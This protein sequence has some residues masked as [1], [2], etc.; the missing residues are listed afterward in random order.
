MGHETNSS[1]AGLQMKRVFSKPSVQEQFDKVD[2]LLSNARKGCAVLYLSFRVQGLRGGASSRSDVRAPVSHHVP[3]ASGGHGDK[4]EAK[5]QQ[6]V[7]VQVTS[8]SP[9][10]VKSKSR[11]RGLKS[12]ALGSQLFS[13]GQMPPT[14]PL[15]VATTSP[16]TPLSPRIY[17]D[18]P[19]AE[20]A[21]GEG[22]N[23]SSS[24]MPVVTPPPPLNLQRHNP[25][26]RPKPVTGTYLTVPG[27]NLPVPPTS[28]RIGLPSSPRA[29][30]PKRRDDWERQLEKADSGDITAR[31]ANFSVLIPTRSERQLSMGRKPPSEADPMGLDD[32]H[33]GVEGENGA[34]NA[35]IKIPSPVKRNRSPRSVSNLP[36]PPAS[37]GFW[38]QSKRSASEAVSG[39]KVDKDVPNDD[40][41]AM[42]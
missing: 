4:Q 17:I 28:R 3:I 11:R 29:T 24:T 30:L 23:Q 34:P 12:V 6:E 20:M 35:S 38:K 25:Q 18:R 36:V 1:S 9:T 41:E 8:K 16:H 2:R 5:G 32:V 13:T 26:Q 22:E 37:R 14:L 10:R 33:V 21:V 31:P 39:R 15:A 27:S 42:L 19:M 40:D 7:G